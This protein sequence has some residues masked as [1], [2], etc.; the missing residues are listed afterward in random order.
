MS[1]LY[2][3]MLLA[4]VHRRSINILVKAIDA[5]NIEQN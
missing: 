2:N 5:T 3:S 1:T 4:V